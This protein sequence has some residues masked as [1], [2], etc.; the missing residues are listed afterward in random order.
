MLYDTGRVLGFNWR[1]VFDREET[2]RDLRV[3]RDELHCNAVKLCGRDLDRLTAAA[4]DA[5]ALGLEVWLSP[6]LWNQPPART[7]TYLSAA[8]EVAEQLRQIRK[9]H[10]ILSVATEAT[11]FLR[12]ILPGRT[13]AARTKNPAPAIRAGRHTEPLADFLAAAARVARASFGGPLTYASL[14]FER[15]DWSLFDFVGVDHYRYVTSE[16]HF[17][18]VLQR[19]F[20][21]GKPVVITE[22]GMRAYEGADRDPNLLSIGL[23]N[24]PSVALHRVPALGRFVRPRLVRGHHVRDEALQARRIAEDLEIFERAGVEGAFVCQ[25][26]EPMLPYSPDPRYDLDM[27]GF[28]L[29]RTRTRT[30]GEGNATTEGEGSA[31]TAGEGNATAAGEIHTPANAE[32]DV[33]ATIQRASPTSA[34]AETHATTKLDHATRPKG[35]NTGNVKKA[36]FHAVANHYKRGQVGRAVPSSKTVPQPS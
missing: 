11:F 26:A 22:F 6:E 2:R 19:Q 20:R 15:V 23:I 31:T 27:S 17:E 18:H 7:L 3:I 25:Y 10:V 14:P 24:W 5:L 32:A 35:I 16:P 4:E 33:H 34:D 30:E 9:N 13:F 21:H 36:A 28:S 29:V 1:P 12:G 8:A